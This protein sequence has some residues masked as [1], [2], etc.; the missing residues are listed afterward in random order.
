LALPIQKDF[1]AANSTALT[2]YDS[3]FQNNSGALAINTN[4]VYPNVSST[5][6]G[7][8]WNGDA[9]N[10][11]QYSQATLVAKPA[12][13]SFF[14]GVGCRHAA[15]GTASYYLYYTANTETW[16]GKMV[17]GSFTAF[18]AVMGGRTV[19][20]VLRI[21]AEGTTIRCKVDGAQQR[22]QTD[23]SLASGAAGLTGYEQSTTLRLD[24]WEA[25]NLGG[26]NATL[27]AALATATALS[28]AA[29]ISAPTATQ[30]ARP[31]STVGAGTWTDQA[32][33]T[34]NIHTTLDETSADDADYVRS[35]L[36]PTG[37]NPYETAL[38]SLTDPA[39]STGHVLRYRLRKE[40][41][42]NAM[43]VTVALM[44]GATQRAT[45]TETDI[46][47]AWA[48][49]ERT[50]TGGEADSITNYAD[51]RV[52]LTAT[53]TTPASPS[54]V[55]SGSGVYTASSGAALSPLAPTHNTGDIGV[56]V[57]HT[58]S[59]TDFA[60]AI[61]GWT[62]IATT[63]NNTAAQRVEIWWRPM[64]GT[65]DDN[66]V[67]AG[68]ASTAVRG[69]RIFCVRNVLNQAPTL[70]RSNNAAST[71]VTFASATAAA[72]NSL[73][74]LV[75]AYEDD[76]NTMGTVTGFT[77]FTGSG[78]TLGTDMQFGMDA[79]RANAASGTVAGGTS[80][81]SGGAFAAS[82]NV[83]LHF[84]FEPLASTPARA[85]VSWIEFATPAA[86]TADGTLTAALTTATALS[87]VAVVGASES[88]VA[89]TA[90][91]TA[92]SPA[93]ALASGAA[94]AG[95]LATA[96]ATSP[97]AAPS[98]GVV[99]AGSLATGTA[100]S[101]ASTIAVVQ[102]ATL[103]AALT[104]A[105]ATSPAG[106]LAAGASLAAGLATATAASP[107]GAPS[108]GAALG[109]NLATA[110]ALSPSSTISAGQAATLGAGLTTASA[111]SPGASLA[112]GAILDG[113]LAAATAQA[114][115]SA[116]AAGQAA[117]LAA[118]LTTAT[119]T[120]PASSLAATAIL[121]ASL[122]TATA[123][124]PAADPSAGAALAGALAAATAASLAATLTGAATFGAGLAG[125]TALAHVA[126][127]SGESFFPG[128]AAPGTT[129]AVAL[130][131]LATA[132]LATAAGSATLALADT[133][134]AAVEL[135]AAAGATVGLDDAP[136]A[137]LAA[138]ATPT[139]TLGMP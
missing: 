65:S 117:T 26:T 1:T 66:P 68:I 84:V 120:S 70:A 95:A 37:A 49:V 119:A 85:N 9:F 110:T 104:T 91:A 54:Y 114:H 50:L 111:A 75:M 19:G 72:A 100:D 13:N 58:S 30:Y 67:V 47:T 55:G 138:T 8:R 133:P 42:G 127:I 39:S 136:G 48:T 62:K 3:G 98:A 31:A 12:S 121:A 93:S 134:G 135:A 139:A 129:A 69:A 73:S 18:G 33:G 21:E 82:P 112:A 118:G 29:T 59:N 60:D 20:E 16:F 14:I 122:A 132:T 22:A 43:A 106:A 130:V 24:D 6:S 103:T 80:T 115:A 52:R 102:A 45:W 4:A 87:P 28:P 99:L 137:T 17:G 15:A 7:V 86:A 79:Y 78:S 2:A 32:G 35:Q 77:A 5:E 107:T 64:D 74:V 56:L 46:G 36:S 81:V 128:G 41:T 53:E 10:A 11:D 83:G 97:V 108:A 51:L 131:A 92:L 105:T 123:T 25:G 34:T 44:E 125:A 113:A 61:T 38:G 96:T 90:T 116:I 88:L 57:A 27:T 76:P 89:A 101:P 40:A 94:L 126:A 63:E 109:A 124:A 23:S 71:T